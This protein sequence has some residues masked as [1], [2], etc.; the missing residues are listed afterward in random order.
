[1][2]TQDRVA[3]LHAL[4]AQAIQELSDL[5]DAHNL[6][7]SPIAPARNRPQAR[8]L[9]TEGIH[10]ISTEGVLKPS[11]IIAALGISRSYYYKILNSKEPS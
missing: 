3:A 4:R 10:R 11:E 5:R 8:E 1:M 6:A 7:F 9:Y 2:P